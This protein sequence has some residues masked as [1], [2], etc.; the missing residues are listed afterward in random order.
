MTSYV[1]ELPTTGAIAFHDFCVDP[2]NVHT[3]H[4]AD[5]TT[6]RAGVRAVLKANKRIDG[7]KDHLR[8]IK[9]WIHLM[10][11]MSCRGVIC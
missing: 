8:I 7:D 3:V 5:A 10:I 1:Y 9:V 2:T 6:A 4:L 11:L